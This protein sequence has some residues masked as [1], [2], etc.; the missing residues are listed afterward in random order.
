MTG[1]WGVIRGD[2][3]PEDEELEVME[4]EKPGCF[5]VQRGLSGWRNFSCSSFKAP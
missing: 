3:D 5:I 1:V 4:A 2:E